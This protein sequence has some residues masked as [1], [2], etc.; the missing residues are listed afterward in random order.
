M[1]LEIASVRPAV[2]AAETAELLRRLLAFRQ[3]FR[4]AYAVGWDAEQLANLR[5]VALATR[6][7]LARDL[8]ALDAFLVQLASAIA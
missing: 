1:T 2:L 4:H 7:P 8:D 3:F 6:V 5:A